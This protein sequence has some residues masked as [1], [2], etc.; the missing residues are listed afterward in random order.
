MLHSGCIAPRIVA[1]NRRLN[2]SVVKHNGKTD[3]SKCVNLY[4]KSG[5]SVH[6]LFCIQKLSELSFFFIAISYTIPFASI[7]NCLPTVVHV[8][9]WLS[10]AYYHLSLSL[11]FC[12]LCLPCAR[13][14]GVPC[15]QNVKSAC[16]QHSRSVCRCIQLQ[17]H[18]AI[19]FGHPPVVCVCT[20]YSSICHPLSTY[21]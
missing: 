5:C 17:S 2:R 3:R 11:F 9:M 18:S 14:N 19:L 15:K 4:S 1:R 21:P 16:M 7:L 8:H 13:N 12:F 10:L 6:I 20:I